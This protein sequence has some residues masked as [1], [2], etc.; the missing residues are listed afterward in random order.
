MLGG[1]Q[2]VG[3]DAPSASQ[4]RSPVRSGSKRSS[5][6]TSGIVWPGPRGPVG[7]QVTAPSGAIPTP[8]LGVFAAAAAGHGRGWRKIHFRSSTLG[9]VR[10]KL[11]PAGH[12]WARTGMFPFRTLVTGVVPEGTDRCPSVVDREI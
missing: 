4:G 2:G 5:P 9:T 8:G 12:I 1:I 7:L 10:R 3:E 11:L 6:R